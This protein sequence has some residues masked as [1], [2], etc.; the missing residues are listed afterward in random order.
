[1]IMPRGALTLAT[2]VLQAMQTL[3]VTD[4]W[5]YPPSREHDKGPEDFCAALLKLLEAKKNF[6]VSFLGSHTSDI[7]G[8]CDST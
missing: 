2:H 1:M 5:L 3:N 7:P 8:L 4:R 6:K